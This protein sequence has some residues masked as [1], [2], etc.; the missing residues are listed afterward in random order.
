MFSDG[1]S[2]FSQLLPH[3]QALYTVGPQEVLV[4]VIKGHQEAWPLSS[5]ASRFFLTWFFHV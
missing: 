5:W 1:T 3:S 2:N 4:T